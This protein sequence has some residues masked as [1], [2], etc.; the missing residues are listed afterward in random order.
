MQALPKETPTTSDGMVRVM[1]SHT[2][3]Q[4][5][6]L[7]IGQRI[8]Q[9]RRN[10][11][12]SQVALATKLRL[13]PGAITQWETGRAMPT[14]EKFSQLAAVLEVEP[15]WLLTG[16]DPEEIRRAQT[17]TEAD[18]LLLLRGMPPAEQQRALEVLRALT[19]STPEHAASAANA[20]K[21]RREE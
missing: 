20:A 8:A 4:D 3:I 21:K 12:L 1:P 9:A 15:G 10:S 11:G 6:N 5:K 2:R 19:R 18:A 14:P 16:D 13:S 17:T 7:A